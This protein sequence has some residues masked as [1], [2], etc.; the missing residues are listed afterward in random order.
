LAVLDL[1]SAEGLIARRLLERG[2]VRVDGFEREAGRVRLA[3]G[4]CSELKGARFWEADVSDWPSLET[5]H[6]SHLLDRYDIV[7]YL[8]LHH[9]LAAA[10]RMT[11]LAGAVERTL[12]W[13]AIRT[14]SALFA[15]DAIAAFMAERG[16][17]LID[18]QDR[19]KKGLGCSYLFRRGTKA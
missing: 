11:S 17:S 15:S 12:D 5:A 7:L 19:G 16:F 1:G 13:F 10:R 4:I 2:A 18:A 3:A 9:H 14:P 8:G 6:K